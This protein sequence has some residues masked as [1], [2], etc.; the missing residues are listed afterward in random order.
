MHTYQTLNNFNKKTHMKNV[1]LL[2]AAMVVSSVLANAQTITSS[3]VPAVGFSQTHNVVNLSG[4]IGPGSAGQGQ[5]WNFAGATSDSSY[6]ETN[7]APMDAAGGS[8]FP[9][10]SYGTQVNPTSGTSFYVGSSAA[11]QLIG[12]YSGDMSGAVIATCSNAID[13]MQFPA[14]FSSA[15]NDPYQVSITSP[16][17]NFSIDGTNDVLVD[18]S[19]T[20]T[21]PT[22]TY[23]NVVRVKSIRNYQYIG[24]PPLPGTVTEGSTTSYL[25]VSPDY[26]GYMLMN[27]SIDVQGTESDTTI[28]YS[29]NPLSIQNVANQALQISP[30]PASEFVTVGFPSGTELNRVEVLDLSGRV[31]AIETVNG[32]SNRLT[33]STSSFTNGLYIVRAVDTKGAVVTSKITVAH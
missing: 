11:L 16:F 23:N 31:V 25:W 13:L 10:A 19:G 3:W 17:L 9:L 8:N 26:P 18:G 28:T 2:S 29:E 14:S 32:K 12:S 15:F 27:Y 21:T 30:N 33:I 20:L 22:G 4:P 1:T 5:T 24:L 6:T 7:L